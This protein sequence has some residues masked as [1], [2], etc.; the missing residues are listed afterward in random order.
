MI[1]AL[2]RALIRRRLK[3]SLKPNP[4]CRSR[5]LAQMKGERR[6]R[7]IRNLADIQAEIG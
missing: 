6:E 3:L 1:A 2:R 7:H 5:A 4:E